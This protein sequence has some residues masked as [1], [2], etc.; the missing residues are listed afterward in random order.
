MYIIKRIPLFLFFCCL[1][2]MLLAQNAPKPELSVKQIMQDPKSWIGTSPSEIQWADDSRTI[3]FQWNPDQHPGDSLYRVNTRNRKIEKASRE[4]MLAQDSRGPY[5][6]TQFTKKL[7]LRNGDLYEKDLKNGRER[8]LSN[9]LNP[10]ND[11]Q[12]DQ[13]GNNI[14]FTQDGNLFKLHRDGGILEQLTSFKSGQEPKKEEL[15]RQ[16]EW[17]KQDQL[18]FFEVLRQRKEEQELRQAKQQQL[19]PDQPKTIYTGSK[20]VSNIRISPDERFVTYTLIEEGEE[21]ST[22]VPSFVTE[23]GYTEMLQARAKV[24][25]DQMKVE[26]GI[27]D[28]QRDTTYTIETK[29]LPGLDKLPEYA[30][31]YDKAYERV[32]EVMIHGPIYPKNG[33]TRALVEIRSIDNK[34]RW[35]ALLDLASGNPRY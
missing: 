8:Q 24:G 12:Y 28:R 25:G 20:S 14:Y 13:D 10:I 32:K 31:E 29:S 2:S 6:N 5:F 34:D 26:T 18:A 27:Y 35:I 15:N 30:A 19:Q 7:Y 23:S 21:E 33:E 3:Y 17:L 4:E 1:H 22:E 9:T 16:D 11:P